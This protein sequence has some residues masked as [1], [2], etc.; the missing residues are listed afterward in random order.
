[1]SKTTIKSNAFAVELSSILHG[2]GIRVTEGVSDAVVQA[3]DF[4]LKEVRQNSPKKTGKY[5]KSWE[6]KKTRTGIGGRKTQ[7]IIHNK[8]CYRLS[9]LL[10]NGHVGPDG[11][12]RVEAKP[13]IEPARDAAEKL[14]E[15]LV[16]NA[17]EEAGDDL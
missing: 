6:K 7:V 10:E 11:V 14:L 12:G 17:I 16:K 9:H 1:M 13:H 2:Y 15:G 3:G 8:D 4:A 5:A